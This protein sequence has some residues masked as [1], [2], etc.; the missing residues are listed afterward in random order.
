MRK[1]FVLVMLGLLGLLA[2]GTSSVAGE[3][4]ASPPSTVS[5]ESTAGLT[6]VSEADSYTA[7]YCMA[8][9]VDL[10][11]DVSHH[12]QA[13]KLIES[14]LKLCISA[15]NASPLTLANVEAGD[16]I[17]ISGDGKWV[18]VSGPLMPDGSII[19]LGQGTVAGHQNVT[20]KFEG[21]LKAGSAL[22]LSGTYT[23]GTAG[24]LPGGQPVSYTILG[25][26]MVQGDI[27]CDGVVGIT[28]LIKEELYIAGLPYTQEEP[29]PDL[30][31]TV[32]SFWGD[33]DCNLA[34]AIPDAIKIGQ[35]IAG[36]PVEQTEPCPDIGTAV[37][38]PGGL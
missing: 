29:C 10:L 38:V 13:I 7:E 22:T 27:D 37:I 21:T 2:L 19:A 12:E 35:S 24:E 23:L 6:S 4:P 18:D 5:V 14:L 1:I 30:N 25:H 9:V 20:A 17:K 28:D 33:V 31:A 36:N 8:F 34:L 16:I 26:A 15:L 3:G 32:A 11:L